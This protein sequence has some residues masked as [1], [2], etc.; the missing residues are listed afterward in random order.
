VDYR[1]AVFIGRFQPFHNSHY[2]VV[3]QGLSIAEEVII[4]VGSSK[5]APN[6]K[7]PWTFEQRSEMI[8]RCLDKDD[9]KRVHIIGVR[10]Y[11]NIDNLWIRD[12]Q[13]KIS[14]FIALSDTVALLGNYKDNSSYY[15]RC[16]PQWEFVPAR[17]SKPLNAS[18]IREEMFSQ[19]KLPIDKVHPGVYSWLHSYMYET[20][21]TWSD[22]GD[23]RSYTGEMSMRQAEWE[24]LK[25]YKE[26]WASAP[27]P[28]T[29]VTADAVVVCSGHVLV[30]R[31][32][33]DPGRG[34]IA[35]PGG[36]VRQSERLQDAAVRELKEETGI[37]VDKPVLESCIVDS[38]MFDHPDR[39]LRGR[40]ITS[41][42]YIKLKNGEL[43]EVRGS[44][45]A[46]SASWMPLMDVMAREQEFYE[47]HAHIINYFVNRG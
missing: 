46:A 9:V 1:A 22:M 7:N 17:S 28:P 29:F 36:F 44:D 10:D 5:T 30:V 42:H 20:N 15:L 11:F 4:V 43:P 13:N 39:S 19:G 33:F 8:R 16:F 41:A 18:D 14:D 27:F 32:K 31:R 25:N 45:D 40:T 38:H 12:I 21:P 2:E 23:G 6:I 26:R 24:F 3:K 37:R 47:D 34:L 35:L